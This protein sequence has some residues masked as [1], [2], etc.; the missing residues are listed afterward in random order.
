[1]RWVVLV[2]FVSMSVW[3]VYQ[4]RVFGGVY[5]AINVL[6][7]QDFSTFDTQVKQIMDISSWCEYLYRKPDLCQLA[8][9]FLTWCEARDWLLSFPVD[10]PGFTVWFGN[11][12]S[13][14]SRRGPFITA[15]WLYCLTLCLYALTI[16]SSNTGR[17][18]SPS[19]LFCFPQ[20]LKKIMRQLEKERVER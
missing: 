14:P 7:W 9:L 20:C 6:K 17:L 4:W 15:A 3:S 1:M 10:F 16:R 13:E 19:S 8:F 12:A 2:L 11:R 18:L 5:T